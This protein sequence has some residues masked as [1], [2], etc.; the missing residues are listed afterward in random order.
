[1]PNSKQKNRD[2]VHRFTE[3]WNDA[4]FERLDELITDDYVLHD[5]SSFFDPSPGLEGV[6]EVI[7][8]FESAFPDGHFEIQ[9]MVVEGNL[10]TVRW[11]GSGTH[12]G[13]LFGVEPTGNE[14]E[15]DGFEM[16]RI[17]G[18]KIAETWTV[19][20]TMGLLQELEVLPELDNL[21]EP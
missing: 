10:V 8:G 20:D 16:E 17:E 6:K 5:P 12:T 13:E 15:F 1:M 14:F 9:D 7:Q 4:D 18:N 11:I 3:A 21:I 19:Y 2:L